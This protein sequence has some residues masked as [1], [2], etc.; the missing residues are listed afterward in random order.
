MKY[1][2]ITIISVL[3]VYML[4]KKFKQNDENVSN[5]A[6]STL[7]TTLILNASGGTFDWILK[8][9]AIVTNREYAYEMT[10]EFNIPYFVLGIVL[11]LVSIILTYLKKTKVTVLNI[12]GYFKRN[13]REHVKESRD[14]RNDF[15]E[16]E[17]NFI[18]IYKKI[19]KK[20]LDKESYE[21][22]IE[23][24]KEDVNAF[25]NVSTDGKRGYTGIA[26]IPLITYAGTFLE[27]ERIDEYYEFD[28]INSNTYYKLKDKGVYPNIKMYYD[29]NSID[30]SKKD[31]V[32]AISITAQIQEAQLQQFSEN[33]NILNIGIDNPSDNVIKYKKQLFKYTNT[34]LE[35][36]QEIFKSF[37]ELNNVHIVCSSQ[38]CLALEI[39]KRCVDDT[40]LPQIIVYQY[41]AQ[42][43]VKY[44][45]GIRING[46]NKGELILANAME[47]LNNV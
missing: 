41:E 21:C 46:E 15:R 32:I 47:D 33:C 4:W 12:N 37:G 22:I 3:V 24:I 40:R 16:Y 18:D 9:I 11:I 30:R 25:K 26:P 23:K 39:G 7:G 43:D 19:F 27:R 13:I 35:A 42:N 36:I 14:L 28:K 38:S 2:I 31:I 8:C 1:L 34:I 17:I 29:I 20:N 44:P 5:I 6:V 45:W 10:Q